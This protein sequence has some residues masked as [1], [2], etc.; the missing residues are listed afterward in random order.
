MY[1]RQHVHLSADADTAVDVGKR[2]GRPVV[3]QVD[4]QALLKDGFKLYVS[5]NNVI[6]IDEVPPQYLKVL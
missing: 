5:K 4:Y 1:K 3:L 2:H 6:L